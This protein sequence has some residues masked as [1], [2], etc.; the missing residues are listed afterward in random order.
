MSEIP[1][2][3]SIPAATVVVFR[4]AAQGGPAELLMLERAGS[5]RF[6]GGAAVF[7]G[8]RID[9]S[10]HELAAQLQHGLDNDEAAARIAA[11]RET[12]E[13]AGLVLGMASKVTA[14]Q[15]AEAR[16]ML[17]GHG[18]LAPVLER[19]GWVPDLAQLHPWARW[20]PVW[21][22]AFDTRFYLADLGT[23]AV[24]VSKDDTEN[25]H[26]FW[27][28]AREAIAMAARGEISVIFP[29][30]RN[31][32][33]LALYDSF[34]EVRDFAGRFPIRTISPVRREIDGVEHLIIPGD[35]GYPVTTQPLAMVKR[36]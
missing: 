16:A 25:S 15:A 4:R 2:P 9:P 36:G 14:E 1:A 10:D 35:L 7:P 17:A 5:M 31:L 27:A 18:A 28:S 30:L 20:C 29:T 12:I 33:R 11:L 23:G 19:F 3:Q 8:G 24:E 34:A 6:A 32:E 13:E 21:H 22:G 26:L